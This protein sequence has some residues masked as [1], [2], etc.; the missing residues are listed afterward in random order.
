MSRAGRIAAVGAGVVVAAGAVAAIVLGVV[1]VGQTVSAGAQAQVC[2]MT[3]GVSVSGQ[4]VRLPGVSDE[5]LAPGDRVRVSPL[6]V[7]EVVAI[8]HGDA[9]PDDDG[10][11]R[12]E[13]RW[14][15]W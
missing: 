9:G 5:S 1:G 7:V 3:L 15:L 8:D 13:L 4:T 11:A 2:G 14:R 10:G 6:C 12:V